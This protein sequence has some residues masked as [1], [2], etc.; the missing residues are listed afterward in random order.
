MKNKNLLRQRVTQIVGQ[1]SKV[2]K[3]TNVEIEVAAGK[4]GYSNSNI[5]IVNPNDD[6]ND[7]LHP[8]IRAYII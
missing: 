3:L 2:L 4:V 6:D 7:D 8:Y 5:V 1:I